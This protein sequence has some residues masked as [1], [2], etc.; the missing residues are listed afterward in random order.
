MHP[1]DLMIFICIG[2]CVGWLA[3]MY[4]ENALRGLIGHVAIGMIGA[5]LAGN[6]CQVLLPDFG[7]TGMIIAGLIGAVLLVQL[8]SLRR[9]A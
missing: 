4:V 7:K 6:A 9:W 1:V 3:A 5:F 2:N 8:V